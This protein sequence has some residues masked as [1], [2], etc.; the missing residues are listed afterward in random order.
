MSS[1]ILVLYEKQPDEW[2]FSSATLGGYPISPI[3][4]TVSSAHSYFFSGWQKERNGRGYHS[5]V[6]G[7]AEKGRKMGEKAS[8]VWVIGP[9]ILLFCEKSHLWPPVLWLQPLAP[10][11]SISWCGTSVVCHF[12]ACLF[13]ALP[14]PAAMACIFQ[15]AKRGKMGEV[16]E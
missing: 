16:V 5:V 7:W 15:V 2:P 13:L 4:V 1:V 6:A 9:A 11:F 10:G 12:S 3:Y 8:F 14:C